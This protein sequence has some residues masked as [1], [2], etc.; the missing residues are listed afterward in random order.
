[1]CEA[2]H[3]HLGK[4]E[5]TGFRAGRIHA[6]HTVCFDIKRR[7][8]EIGDRPLSVPSLRTY[9]N[10]NF[11]FLEESDLVLF[12]WLIIQGLFFFLQSFNE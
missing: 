8:R 12:D 7:V 9:G 6:N 11:L 10:G 4:L 3:C 1:M 5:L 2:F